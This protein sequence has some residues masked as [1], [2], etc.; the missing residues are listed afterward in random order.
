MMDTAGQDSAVRPSA[1]S[2][3]LRAL[4]VWWPILPADTTAHLVRSP[5]LP[6]HAMHAHK[7]H[8]PAW[9]P[10]EYCS[11]R[12]SPTQAASL[13]LLAQPVCCPQHPAPGHSCQLGNLI[14][15]WAWEAHI[16][17][18]ILHQGHQIQLSKS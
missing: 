7:R 5:V 8:L 15:V 18:Y 16:Y 4:H 13:T 10:T 12:S 14:S 6:P 3:A 11:I 1:C 17:I 9:L 2:I